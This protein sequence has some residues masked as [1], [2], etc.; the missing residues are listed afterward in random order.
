M[1]HG[2]TTNEAALVHFLRVN[3]CNLFHFSM[4]PV[5][6]AISTMA[7]G[8]RSSES[9]SQMVDLVDETTRRNN[10]EKLCSCGR[11]MLFGTPQ[12]ENG[13]LKCRSTKISEA[14]I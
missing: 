10:S 12:E 7:M 14:F 13:W 3:L 9:A 11:D 1:S 8:F 5:K 2:S 6:D 4:R